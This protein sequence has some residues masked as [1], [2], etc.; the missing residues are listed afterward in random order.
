VSTG[1][2][3]KGRDIKTQLLEVLPKLMLVGWF[4]LADI[5]RELPGAANRSSLLVLYDDRGNKLTF[6]LGFADGRPRVVEVD[7]D[8]PPFATTEVSMHVDTFIKI[9]KGQTDFIAT[10]LYDLVD[11]RS[12]DGL[13]PEYHVLLWAAFYDRVARLLK[14]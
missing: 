2:G 1:T 7:P 5:L 3:G 4:K 11:V 13:P 14:R 6:W 10:Y 12:N 9:L 8:N